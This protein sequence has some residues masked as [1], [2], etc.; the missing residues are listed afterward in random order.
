MANLQVSTVEYPATHQANHR[1]QA[2]MLIQ[3]QLRQSR[4]C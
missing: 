1:L 2:E 4:S 3:H